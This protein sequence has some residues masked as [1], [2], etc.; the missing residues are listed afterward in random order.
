MST[1]KKLLFDKNT[2]SA[3]GQFQTVRYGKM[4]AIQR[5][6][7]SEV[8]LYN[9]WQCCGKIGKKRVIDLIVY[10]GCL[11]WILTEDIPN[12]IFFYIISLSVF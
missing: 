6:P 4:F 1:I 10:D 11:K 7:L 9:I 2:K 3:A 5:C 12:L 8:L